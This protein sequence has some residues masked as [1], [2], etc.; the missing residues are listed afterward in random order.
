MDR[1]KRV[2][3]QEE[4]INQVTLQDLMDYASKAQ[5]A[6]MSLTDNCMK[7]NNKH[8]QMLASNVMKNVADLAD[9][10]RAAIMGSTATP[11]E[12]QQL[13]Q[14]KPSDN[15]IEANEPEGTTEVKPEMDKLAESK[16]YY[17]N[18]LS[19]AKA[20]IQKLTEALM[21]DGLD[22]ET[23]QVAQELS[24][25]T[26]DSLNP[27]TTATA[28]TDATG[29][30]TTTTQEPAAAATQPNCI[31]LSEPFTTVLE[32]LSDEQ[33]QQFKAQVTSALKAAGITDSEYMNVVNELDG[34]K[35]VDD[36]NFILDKLYDYADAHNIEIKTEPEA[37]QPTQ[38]DNING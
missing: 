14:P 3:L 32:G 5:A 18:L 25:E 22:D 21:E 2:R 17:A 6:M 20:T 11:E 23:Q 1:N 29:D 38:E 35:T 16:A 26:P 31:D 28:G 8:L 24:S 13:E 10:I 27:S 37:A 12:P 9:K 15:M 30:T 4:T 7:F 36:F 19:E 33:F 34:V